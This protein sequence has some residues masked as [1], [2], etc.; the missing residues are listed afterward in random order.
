M[1]TIKELQPHHVRA[2]KR[3]IRLVW[4][5]YFKD[6]PR[7]DVR[8]HFDSQ[9][10]LA[11]LNGAA[12]RYRSNRGIFLVVLD[13][14]RVIGTGGFIRFSGQSCE[15]KHVFLLEKFRSRGIGYQLTSQLIGRA[16]ELGYKKVVLGTSK[17][18]K[19]AH[20]LY[21]KLGFKDCGRLDPRNLT[22]Y[23]ELAL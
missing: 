7:I 19:E 2:A 4:K 8:T 6:D 13:G 23:M 17:R 22:D 5:E 20:K 12:S 11:D 16:R 15:F 18:F 21:Y 10:S 1:V 14:K 9:Q 3:I